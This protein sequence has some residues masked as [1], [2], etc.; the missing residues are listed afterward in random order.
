M[1][2]GVLILPAFIVLSFLAPVYAESEIF[3]DDF[4]Y[5]DLDQL[6][7]VWDATGYSIKLTGNEVWITGSSSQG[8]DL[9]IT[10]PEYQDF[11]FEAKVI[12]LSQRIYF[13]FKKVL[14]DKEY[15]YSID[16]NP[17]EG[18]INI[19]RWGDGNKELARASPTS[20]T[21]E[22]IFY[23]VEVVGNKI[24]LY[25]NGEK[26]LEASEDVIAGKGDRIGFTAFWNG[27]FKVD[28]VKVSS[29]EPPAPTNKKIIYEDDNVV[30]VNISR[31]HIS[32][33]GENI[34]SDTFS[35]VAKET[36]IKVLQHYN[37]ISKLAG[38]SLGVLIDFINLAKVGNYPGDI[39]VGLI[40]EKD[41]SDKLIVEQYEEVYPFVIVSMEALQPTEDFEIIVK[42][43]GLFGTVIKEIKVPYSAFDYGSNTMYEIFFKKP[44]S[45]SE[46]GKYEITA[47]WSE[48][49]VKGPAK[50]TVPGVDIVKV[51]PEKFPAGVSVIDATVEIKV[52]N[53]CPD[54]ILTIETGLDKYSEKVNIEATTITRSVVVYRSTPTITI[55][56]P[57]G[58][59]VYLDSIQ[60]TG[61]IKPPS[62]ELP[63]FKLTAIESEPSKGLL[64]IIMGD[65]S[66]KSFEVKKVQIKVDTSEIDINYGF[67]SEM[68]TYLYI[69]LPLQ[70]CIV[71]KV[72]TD[73][74]DD[75]L[76]SALEGVVVELATV[77][78]MDV[79]KKYIPLNAVTTSLEVY[80]CTEEGDIRI[81][82]DNKEV[83]LVINKKAVF[84][85]T[86]TK[87]LPDLTE[88]I[89][90]SGEWSGII[91][92]DTDIITIPVKSSSNIQPFPSEV[93]ETPQPE[94]KE[95]QGPIKS[96]INTIADFFRSIF[97]FFG[98]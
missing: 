14:G 12:P 63:L 58:D 20:F 68:K 71:K 25:K 1:R 33:D 91:T 22:P 19:F 35:F 50:I 70:T 92:E 36:G 10:T 4:K 2:R 39:Y 79:T 73:W 17:H 51:F 13:S 83:W 84:K 16:D 23:K 49:K 56:F 44:I 67:A 64:N 95:T 37:I 72:F 52:V 26:T 5:S 30:V 76:N 77:G 75:P 3:F 98:R 96:I 81:P 93:I 42:S 18:W 21:G 74:I 62:G 46:V 31:S 41:V 88:P 87:F 34:L 82:I 66:I 89:R 57:C 85:T 80:Q 38:F 43:N 24:T 60:L 45:F 6:R 27:D 94:K 69:P 9:Y 53:V 40:S 47:K 11:V 55:S 97:N 61:P 28:W 90:G 86:Y 65:G 32:G 54:A 78:I 7:Q 59:K 48:Y 8:S 15:G 29:L